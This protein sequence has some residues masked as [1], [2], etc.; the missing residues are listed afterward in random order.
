MATGR[1]DD[2]VDR[3]EADTFLEALRILRWSICLSMK[4]HHSESEMRRSALQSLMASI[5][6]LS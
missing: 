4:V 3:V 2:E 5:T 1:E 6:A